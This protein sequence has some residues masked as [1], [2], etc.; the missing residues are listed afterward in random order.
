MKIKT[1]HIVIA[2]ILLALLAGLNG[3]REQ[4]LRRRTHGCQADPARQAEGEDAGQ[5]SRQA[6]GNLLVVADPWIPGV[7]S[8]MH[9]LYY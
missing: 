2:V 7:V 4:C 8:A 9:L 1:R 6:H 5:E 3:C